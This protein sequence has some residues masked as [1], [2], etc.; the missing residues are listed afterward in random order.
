MLRN[1]WLNRTSIAS[2]IAIENMSSCGIRT[3]LSRLRTTSDRNWLR[4]V[5]AAAVNV[6]WWR[7]SCGEAVE[8]SSCDPWSRPRTRRSVVV[9]GQME[10]RCVRRVGGV[11][12]PA[13]VARGI[14]YGA[15]RAYGG[16]SGRSVS[17]V[18]PTS[19]AATIWPPMLAFSPGVCH[20][21]RRDP[22]RGTA[23]VGESVGLFEVLG[24]EHDRDPVAGRA[25]D[26][27]HSAGG[28][29]GR[30]PWW[31]HRGL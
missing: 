28:R 25:R 3:V 30:V 10:T 23:R 21:R 4:P 31:V 16:R 29:V 7:S 20:R 14:G 6:R 19:L 15:S 26:E 18:R 13:R 2:G 8:A 11:V 17:S 12:D 22:G 24:G 5:G 1:T 27:S 9:G